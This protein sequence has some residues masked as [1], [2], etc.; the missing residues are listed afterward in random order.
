MDIIRIWILPK[1]GVNLV[2]ESL[3]HKP[4]T[5]MRGKQEKNN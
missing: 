5:M 4:F 2:F 1:P 3:I